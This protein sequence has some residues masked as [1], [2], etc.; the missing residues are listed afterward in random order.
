MLSSEIEP[1]KP[2]KT[3]TQPYSMDC[4]RQVIN[5]PEGTAIIGDIGDIGDGAAQVP[6]KVD[7]LP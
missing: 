3:S 1:T 2:S 5:D 4:I 6:Q 7:E